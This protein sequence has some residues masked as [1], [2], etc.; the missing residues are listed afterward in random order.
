[1][2]WILVYM[3]LTWLT[4][5]DQSG[6]QTSVKFAEAVWNYKIRGIVHGSDYSRLHVMYTCY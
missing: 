2:A 3:L 1:M 4:L 6:M 5:A